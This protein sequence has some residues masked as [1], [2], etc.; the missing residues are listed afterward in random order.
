MKLT[1]YEKE[2]IV[3]SIMQDVPPINKEKR[4]TDLQASLVKAMSPEARKLYNRTP[5]ALRT[6]NFGEIIYTGSYVS[7]ELIVGDVN[8]EAISELAKPYEAEDKAYCDTQRKLHSIVGGCNTLAQLKKLLPEFVSYFP[9]ETEPTKNLP[10]VVNMV[11]DLSKLGW[12][13]GKAK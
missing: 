8:K 3:R 9:S 11:A 6:Y 13:K 5:S 2:A 1:K 10:A 4:R 7:R 12:P